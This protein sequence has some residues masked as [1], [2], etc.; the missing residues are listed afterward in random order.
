[1]A[2][3]QPGAAGVGEAPAGAVPR[4]A[5]GTTDSG[6][7]RGTGVWSHPREA[8][9]RSRMT[10]SQVQL[11]QT[12]PIFGGINEKILGYLLEF[13]REVTRPQGAYFFH[14]KDPGDSMFVLERGEVD[15]V[16]TWKDHAYFLRKIGIGDCFGILTLLD[17][18]PRSGSAIARR[19]CTAIEIS[20]ANMYQIYKK[21]PEQFMLMQMNLGREVSRRL[22]EADTQL[23]KTLVEPESAVRQWIAA[24]K[25]DLH[26]I[27][28]PS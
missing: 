18:G 13:T 12:M 10:L 27:E 23:F 22:R 6:N 20:S 7:S 3:E 19:N 25:Y 9:N 28:T 16:K 2:R 15:I 17:L 8:P 26:P 4:P 14:E 24:D 21:D 11:L 1:M 5:T